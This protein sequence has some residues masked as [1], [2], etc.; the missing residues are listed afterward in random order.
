MSHF[1]YRDGALHVEQVAIS[2]IATAVGTPFYCYS[3]ATLVEKYAAFHDAVCRA[4]EAGEISPERDTRTLARFLAATR[5]GLIV[6]AKTRP[7]RT[8]LEAVVRQALTTLD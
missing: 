7:P 6:T 4:Q 5:H 2:D 1:A 8:A 3:S